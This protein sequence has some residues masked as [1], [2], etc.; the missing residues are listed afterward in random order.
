[1]WIRSDIPQ[2]CMYHLEFD[3]LIHHV[4]SMIFE[5]KINKEIWYIIL[6]Y[7]NPYVS[8]N[9]LLSKLIKVYECLISKAKEII[10]L[11]DL[12][13][14]MQVEDND[15]TNDLCD[16]YNLTNLFKE[17]TC[18]KKPEGTLIDP[19]IVRNAKCFKKSINIFC[20]C[21]DFHHLVGCVTK[22]HLP[23]RKPFKIAYR[24]LRNFNENNFKLDVARIPFHISDI[25]IDEGDKYW[26]RNKL[27]TDVLNDHAPL[28]ELRMTIYH[29]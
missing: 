16:L 7:K 21:S 25:F 29:I 20:D 12:N 10:L 14:N 24:S 3:Q 19:I 13:I 2:Q 23:P 9:I 26:V 11:G 15:L 5:L 22:L 28:K 6:V 18:Y 8:N 4:E 17:P 27:F 1:M